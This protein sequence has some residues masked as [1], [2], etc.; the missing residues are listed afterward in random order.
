ML[1]PK[2]LIVPLLTI[3]SRLLSAPATF[4]SP[5]MLVSAIAS[6]CIST[7]PLS[8]SFSSFLN[9]SDYGSHLAF[10]ISAFRLALHQQVQQFPKA[11]PSLEGR[12]IG[13]M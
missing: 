9:G 5:A 11:W 10:P 4:T 8:F 2:V 12:G 13:N 7:H 1:P 3:L 6:S